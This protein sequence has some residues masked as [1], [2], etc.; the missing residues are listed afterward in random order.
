MPAIGMGAYGAAKAGINSITKTLAWELAP[1]VRVNAI[2][3]G[4]IL[5][6]TNIGFLGGVK[7]LLIE[8]T[9][10]KR[11]GTPEDIALAAIFLAS[12]ASDWMTGKLLEIDGGMEYSYN[13]HQ[14][15]RTT[16]SHG[17]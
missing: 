11:T 6:P 5:T 17:A 3:P 16:A 15:L 8:A 7:D 4:S 10:M 14:Q 1:H 12:S 2:L 9:P 13:I